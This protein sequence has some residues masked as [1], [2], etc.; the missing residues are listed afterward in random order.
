MPRATKGID[1]YIYKTL[2]KI[3]PFFCKN[4]IHPNIITLLNILNGLLLYNNLKNCNKKNIL[5]FQIILYYI[6][7]CLDGEVARQ[8]NKQS[9]LGGYLDTIS[10][11]LSISIILMYL[12]SKFL[13]KHFNYFK[14]NYIFLVNIIL[15]LVGYE[16]IDLET[17]E[18]KNK[19]YTKLS[20]NIFLVVLLVT[21][22]VTK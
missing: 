1:K 21:Y 11:I 20:N 18:S 16:L 19:I 13:L 6:F 10:D 4:N 7:D 22:L 9:K 5:I 14:S 8:C 17:H 3:V 12:I 2:D 15:T